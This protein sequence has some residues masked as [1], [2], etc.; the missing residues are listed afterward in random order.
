MNAI[1]IESIRRCNLFLN[2]QQPVGHFLYDAEPRQQLQQQLQQQQQQQQKFNYGH[3]NR[4]V[5]FKTRGIQ[6]QQEFD[7]DS[8]IPQN[9]SNSNIDYGTNS[10][11]NTNSNSTTICNNNSRRLMGSACDGGGSTPTPKTATILV[12]KSKTKTGLPLVMK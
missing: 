8:V 11:S 7:D 4:A 3:G 5:H 12:S 10:S 1:R 2:Q 9:F 6:Q